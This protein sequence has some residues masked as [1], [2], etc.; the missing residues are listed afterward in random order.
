VSAVANSTPSPDPIPKITDPAELAALNALLA[1]GL[2]AMPNLE[3]LVYE[4]L[5]D[6]AD[7]GDDC[8]DLERFSQRKE[9]R[10][11]NRRGPPP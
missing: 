2:D 9:T 8:R 5:R 11:C 1:E 3:E 4:A 10:A 6:G 7:E